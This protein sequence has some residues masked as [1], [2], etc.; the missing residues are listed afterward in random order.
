MYTDW[1]HRGKHSS[2]N[3]SSWISWWWRVVRRYVSVPHLEIIAYSC[4]CLTGEA[5]RI[6]RRNYT[7]E[8]SGVELRTGA[9]LFRKY[10]DINQKIM[11]MERCQLRWM[12]GM[13]Q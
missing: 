12:F 2:V 7:A 8:R 11:V 9:E 1:E 4:I 3:S 10:D 13:R 5:E 6:T